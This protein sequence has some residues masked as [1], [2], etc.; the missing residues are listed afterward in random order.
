MRSVYRR[1]KPAFAQPAYPNPEHIAVAGHCRD[2]AACADHRASIHRRLAVSHREVEEELIGHAEE[3]HH[4]GDV[5]FIM[6][7]ASNLWGQRTH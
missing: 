5:L 3:I 4:F 1:S 2:D 7:E 6:I